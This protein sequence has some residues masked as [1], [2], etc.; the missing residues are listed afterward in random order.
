MT[1]RCSSTLH[2]TTN[3]APVLGTIEGHTTPTAPYR[4]LCEACTRQ[5]IA[6]EVAKGK[7]EIRLPHLTWLT[8]TH[9]VEPPKPTPAST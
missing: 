3:P 9:H 8:H 6:N 1:I 2:G 4:Y 7:T 5:H